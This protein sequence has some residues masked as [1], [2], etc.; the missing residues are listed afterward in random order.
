METLFSYA[1]SNGAKSLDK[2]VGPNG[3]FI[4]MKM[5]DGTTKTLPV[6]GKSQ[7]GKLSEY[8][9]LITDDGQAIATV[10]EYKTAESVVF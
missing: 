6:G 3:A 2:V 4:S 5:I 10:N 1:K 8:N 9:I 7:N